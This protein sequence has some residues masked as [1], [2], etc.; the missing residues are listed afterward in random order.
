MKYNLLDVTKD[1]K[2]QSFILVDVMKCQTKLQENA[3]RKVFGIMSTLK[4]NQC[5]RCAKSSYSF[6][7]LKRTHIR[8]TLKHGSIL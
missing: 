2:I 7:N 5:K 8:K 6:L 4:R 3:K 1:G